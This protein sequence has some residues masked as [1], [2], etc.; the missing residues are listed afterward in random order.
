MD[1][2]LAILLIAVVVVP[3]AVGLPIQRRNKKLG[4][5]GR[6]AM[7]VGLAAMNELFHPAAN[8]TSIVVEERKEA[9]A[10]KPSPE[11]K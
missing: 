3:L 1:A 2:G 7:G 4:K 6:S 5:K 10:P 11:D 9:I 8:E